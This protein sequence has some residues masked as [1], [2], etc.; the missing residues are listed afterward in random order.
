MTEFDYWVDKIARFM[1]FGGIS[2]SFAKQVVEETFMAAPTMYRGKL[3][4]A[5]A[6]RVKEMREQHNY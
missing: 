1:Y 4:E 6:R 2:P 5:V 3:P